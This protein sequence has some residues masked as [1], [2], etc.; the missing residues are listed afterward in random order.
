MAAARGNS[1]KFT[2]KKGKRLA[3]GKPIPRAQFALPGAG[4][5]GKDAYPIDTPG[6]ARNALSRGAANASP[7]QQA[8]I[9]AKVKAK[10][11]KIA[12][13]GKKPAAKRGK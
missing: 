12:V 10:Y 7:A 8:T 5:G 3:G 4:P 13:G 1:P 2:Q 9:K 11:P 6:R